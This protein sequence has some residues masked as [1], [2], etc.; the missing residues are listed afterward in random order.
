MEIVDGIHANLDAMASVCMRPYV[1]GDGISRRSKEEYG[2]WILRKGYRSPLCLCGYSERTIDHILSQPHNCSRKSNRIWLENS[3][4]D[5]H[6]MI[7]LM[8]EVGPYGSDPVQCVIFCVEQLVPCLTSNC[9]VPLYLRRKTGDALSA[10][11]ALEYGDFDIFK[12]HKKLNTIL[13]GG[14][15]VGVSTVLLATMFPHAQIVALEP[16][17]VRH[18][19]LVL[20]TQNFRNVVVLR[21]TIWPFPEMLRIWSPFESA[22]SREKHLR[23]SLPSK[24]LKNVTE[25]GV[26][27]GLSVNMLLDL[28]NLK[29]F[30]MLK[31]EIDEGRTNVLQ[32]GDN[33]AW[34]SLCKVVVVSNQFSKVKSNAFQKDMVRN[35][36][37]RYLGRSNIY[38][39]FLP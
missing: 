24:E 20:N 22:I 15:G 14:P 16:L 25:M 4:V 6:Q 27:Q 12:A 31:L 18:E 39:V 32:E 11:E 7:S 33:H 2:P 9:L 19:I 34:L 5:S 3:W 17:K 37:W 1:D 29:T 36:R 21:G 30:D 8:S 38:Q 23:V 13:D 35:K 10:V 26:T 28:F